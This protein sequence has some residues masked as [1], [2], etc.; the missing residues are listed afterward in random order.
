[1]LT[2][3]QAGALERLQS[4]SLKIIYGFDR[5]YTALLKSSRLEKL[6]DRREKATRKFAE[7]CLQGKYSD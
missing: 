2:S 5:T 6:D 3:T 4:Q 1:M 7:K